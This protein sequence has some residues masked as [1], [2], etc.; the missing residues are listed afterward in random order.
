MKFLTV[1]AFFSPGIPNLEF[2]KGME[3]EHCSE[4]E[5]TTLTYGITTS[6]FKEWNIVVRRRSV[7]D[8][9]KKSGRIV[10]DYEEIIMADKKKPKQMRA[11]LKP[12][13]IIA[14]ILYSGPMVIEAYC[15]DDIK[16]SFV[17]S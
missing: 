4:I 6:P 11:D 8:D 5:F 10:R 16:L 15:F 1:W 13:E 14:I 2:M 7:P 17:K 9:Q 3:K 12:E